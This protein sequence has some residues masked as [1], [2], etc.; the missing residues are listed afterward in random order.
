MALID[1][2]ARHEVYKKFNQLYYDQAVGIPLVLATSHGY[3]QRWVEGRVM[4]PIFSNIY[5]Y[6]ISKAADRQGPD[7]FTV[8]TTGGPDTLDPALSYDTASGE[9]VQNVYETLVFYDG[10]AT[11]EIRTAA[12]QPNG[13]P[14]MMAPSG[15]SPSA[16]VS[17]SM[18]VA[19]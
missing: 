3:E 1:P 11:D 10:E 16:K 9:V 19:T 6:T 15:P 18:K 4:N 7:V 14:R 17:S 13:P 8:M 5:Y 12:G 2:A